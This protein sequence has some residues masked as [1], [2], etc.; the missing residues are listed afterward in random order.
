MMRF[1]KNFTL[2]P[3]ISQNVEK[4]SLFGPAR[5]R[6]Y[7]S[8]FSSLRHEKIFNLE[9][10]ETFFW[11]IK[12]FFL[13]TKLIIPK[14]LVSTKI[15]KNN[16]S[17][18]NG[19]IPI[20]PSKVREVIKRIRKPFLLKKWSF[21]P[22][23]SANQVWNNCKERLQTLQSSKLFTLLENFYLKIIHKNYPGNIYLFKVNNRN[24][25]KRYEIMFKL[26]NKSTRTTSLVFLL[27]PLNLFHKFF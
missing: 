18:R 6:K 23:R 7:S 19:Y 3:W 10:S 14:W 15:R 22:W 20:A 2:T 4:S 27:L 5:S 21:L 13:V 16:H 9:Q 11:L 25:R 17:P 12:S 8:I 1:K 24:T 26:N